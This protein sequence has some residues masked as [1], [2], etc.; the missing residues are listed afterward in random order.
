M[1][2][3]DK[4][5]FLPPEARPYEEVRTDWADAVASARAAQARLKTRTLS[6]LHDAGE[7]YTDGPS[8]HTAETGARKGTKTAA[9]HL[10]PADALLAVSKHAHFGAMKY[11]TDGSDGARN[12]EQGLPYSV[13][14]AA[15]MRH[16]LLWWGGE[17]DDTDDNQ[18]HLNAVGFWALALL[19]G[20]LRG[21]PFIDD[22]P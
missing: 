12:W 5:G 18:P 11:T 20:E 16:L 7:L 9:T 2:L 1:K 21:E 22:R 8:M 6:E 17:K 4:T 14:Y 13:M 15:L 19:A 10:L 3:S